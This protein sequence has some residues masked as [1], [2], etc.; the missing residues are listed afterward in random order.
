MNVHLLKVLIFVGGTDDITAHR[1]SKHGNLK[2]ICKPSGS[3]NGGKIVDTKILSCLVE[4]AGND[5]IKTFA[6]KGEFLELL[7]QFENIKNLSTSS[8]KKSIACKFPVNL[9]NE[10]CRDQCGKDFEELLNDSKYN[11]KLVLVNDRMR[12]DR[13]LI[14]SFIS[15]VASDIVNDIKY[16]L[17]KAKTVEIKTFIVVGGFSNSVVV[18]NTLK[19]EFTTVKIIYPPFEVDLAVVKGAVLYG[20]NPHYIKPCSKLDNLK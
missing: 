11:K 19:R 9:L 2:E 17:K 4:I 1:I 15:K 5:V 12:I 8:S 20:H 13:E 18:R 3:A 10:L 16:A 14:V 7:D 6:T